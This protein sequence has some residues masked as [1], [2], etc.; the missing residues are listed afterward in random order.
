[1]S[2]SQE[3]SIYE[4]TFAKSD[5][6]DAILVVD[7]KK[8]H[9][10]KALLSY[11]SS[12]FNALFNSEFK[13]KSMDE[14]E[15][16]DLDFEDFAT[17]LSLIQKIPIS[18]K[19]EG[20]SEAQKLSIYEATF[21]KSDKTD[22][23]LVVDGKKLHVNKALLSYHSDYFDALFNSEFKEKSM[24]EISIEEVKFE[25]FAVVLSFVHKNPIRVPEYFTN[26]KKAEE[27]LKLADRF[28]LPA[29]TGYLECSIASLDMYL[30]DKL[31]LADKH[32]LDILLVCTLKRFERRG[33]LDYLRSEIETYS[34]RTKAKVMERLFDL[35]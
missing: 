23:I 17:V 1:M 7:G 27:L 10:N 35:Y 12:Y 32:K 11:H 26:V 13:E 22:A 3:L 9:V 4:K 30:T 20:M 25:D 21:V 15:I 29:A 33:D 28:D 24:D 6:T 19:T 16:K 18:P 8:L 31:R 34:D 2:K 14:I 5:E